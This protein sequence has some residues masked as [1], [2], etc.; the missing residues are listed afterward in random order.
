MP[1]TETRTSGSVVHMRPLPSDSTTHDVAGLGHGE[2]RAADADRH[3]EELRAQVRARRRGQLGGLVGDLDAQLAPEERGDLGAV[4]VD[5]GHEDVRGRVAG[6]LDD[7]LGQVGLH[8]VHADA[9]RA[10]R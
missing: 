10:R 1:T 6:E 2:V 7:Q 9:P 8:R 4:A 5:G 3:R